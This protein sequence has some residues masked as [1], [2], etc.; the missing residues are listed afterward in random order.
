MVSDTKSRGHEHDHALR[1]EVEFKVLARRNKLVGLWAAGEM[2][3]GGAD[4]EAYAKDVVA[5]DLD[6]PGDAD[7]IRKLLDDFKAKGLA[8]DESRLR[9][10]LDEML[11]EAR[12]QLA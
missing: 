6:E 1:H 12:R 10:K 11:P 7:V 3:L 9:A 2:G 5:A 4:A 8:M